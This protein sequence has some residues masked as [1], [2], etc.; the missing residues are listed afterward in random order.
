L[1]PG[2]FAVL[3]RPCRRNS[4]TCL[5]PSR[6]LAAPLFQSKVFFARQ[7]KRAT[8][9]SYGEE[10]RA[11]EFTL[12][13]IIFS[14]IIYGKEESLRPKPGQGTNPRPICLEL[15]DQFNPDLKEF[16][17]Q[18]KIFRQFQASHLLPVSESDIASA[19]PE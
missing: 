7:R 2:G 6:P 5:Q 15:N 17:R 8:I 19:L 9:P 12:A 11:G 10:K 14:A 3:S 1:R 18:S 13:L 16:N 4:L